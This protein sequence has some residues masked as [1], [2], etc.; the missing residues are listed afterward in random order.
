MAMD[1]NFPHPSRA[2]KAGAI[3]ADYF[4]LVATATSRQATSRTVSALLAAPR[5]VMSEIDALDSRIAFFARNGMGR[6]VQPRGPF[7]LAADSGQAVVPGKFES[8]VNPDG[9]NNIKFDQSEAVKP[10][11]QVAERGTEVLRLSC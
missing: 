9:S 8:A 2:A 6:T 7:W 3:K 11:L 4:A 10:E 1:M 5:G